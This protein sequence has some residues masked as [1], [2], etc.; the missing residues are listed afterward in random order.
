MTGFEKIGLSPVQDIASNRCGLP[1]IQL[2]N[3]VTAALK[4]DLG[5]A[6]DITSAALIPH[7]M[8]WEAK[9][10]ARQ[11]GIIAGHEI[12]RMAFALLDATA[13]YEILI[14]DGG[15][16]TAGQTLAQVKGN[17]R[18]LLAAERTALN[19][20]CHLSGIAT[21]THKM[22]E[23]T[24]PHK[25]KICDTRKT[26]PGLRMLEK[27]AVKM[28]GGANHRF[29]LDDA[30]LIKDNHIAVAGGI[31]SALQSARSAAGH[32]VK[33]EIE[34]DTIQQ[35]QQILSL[36]DY[37]WPDIVLLDNMDISKLTE[38][39]RLIAGRFVVEASGRVNAQS[40]AAIASTGVDIISSGFI[41]HSAP[42]LDI[43]L[44]SS[45]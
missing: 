24:R 23:A 26:T 31:E 14:Q 15:A 28:G 29:G 42:I 2:Q 1:F 43:G 3:L 41:T 13:D 38:S 16:I 40:V 21:L 22:V 4:E 45:V 25:A 20:I 27:Y 12:A 17:A 11:A 30:I 10:V 44:D 36:P 8:R 9:L 32:M 33:I 19:Y 37:L 5:R 34:V 39:V 35:L 6:G 18:A 7:Q